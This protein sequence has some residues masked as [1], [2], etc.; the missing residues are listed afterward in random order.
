LQILDCAILGSE[1]ND[2]PSLTLRR[3]NFGEVTPKRLP[4]FSYTE[5]AK[6]GGLQPSSHINKRKR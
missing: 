4:A 6:I 1:E 2:P 5:D 3:I